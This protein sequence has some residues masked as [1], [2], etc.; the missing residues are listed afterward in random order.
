M[1]RFFL[2][3][4]GIVALVACAPKAAQTGFNNDLKP[5]L[6]FIPAELD[7]K[8]VYLDVSTGKR[9]P[10]IPKYEDASYFYGGIA[11]VKLNGEMFYID[12]SFKPIS[13]ARY[14]DATIFNCGLALT[15]RPNGKIEAIDKSCNVVFTVE[16]AEYASGF[17]DGVSLFVTEDGE[18][19]LVDINGKTIIKPGLY[20]D[21]WN[22]VGGYVAVESNDRWG[23]STVD[24]DLVIKCKYDNV[25]F[26]EESIRAGRVVVKNNDLFGVVDL[27]GKEVIPCEYKTLYPEPDGTYLFRDSHDKYGWLDARG[28]ELIEPIFDQVYSLF[29]EEGLA[30]VMK[31]ERRGFIDREGEWAIEPRFQE[32]RGFNE[33]I[34]LVEKEMGEWGAI[35]T[36]GEYVIKPKY[37]QL[38]ILGENLILATLNREYALLDFSGK[39][40]V[41]MSDRYEYRTDGAPFGVH[42]QYLDVDPLVDKMVEE[43]NQLDLS[44]AWQKAS[45]GNDWLYGY[46]M[47]AQ[48]HSIS[49]SADTHREVTRD[50]YGSHEKWIVS[51]LTISF[52]MNT[53]KTTK[54]EDQIFE[55]LAKRLGGDSY[56]KKLDKT[57]LPGTEARMYNG[58]DGFSIVLSPDSSSGEMVALPTADGDHSHLRL[59]GAL[60]SN[61]KEYPIVM[62]LNLTPNGAFG[63]AEDVSGYYFYQSKSED[64]HINL[65][66]CVY[67][68]GRVSLDSSD[69]TETFEGMMEDYAHF[70]GTWT[71]VKGDKTSSMSFNLAVAE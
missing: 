20:S 19:G 34:A 24:G 39:T 2:L 68:D 66:G 21:L 63:I 28:N 10:D 51:S 42:S 7:G 40:V 4:A 62:V 59:Y 36:K 43:I 57:L 37:D 14:A 27:N 1:K 45:E 35:D 11:L 32:V 31:K 18:R 17:Y 53:E 15:V 3:L 49:I 13:S 56:G 44:G 26:T 52:T 9:V 47:S 29:G 69:M 64:N 6:R 54:N 50:F 30:A 12:T 70:N 71:L 8:Y 23:V 67:T 58:D 60:K 25:V 65:G 55:K 38:T 48:N 41:K 46:G 61:G 5:E 22:R 33:G 16:G